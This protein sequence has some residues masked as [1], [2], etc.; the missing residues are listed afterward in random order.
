VNKFKNIV[1]L[2]TDGLML[3]NTNSEKTIEYILENED[4]T[5]GTVITNL[6][7]NKY[8]AK[9]NAVAGAKLAF[10]GFKK[11]HPHDTQSIIR[12][13]FDERESD[14]S[15]DASPGYAPSSESSIPEGENAFRSIGLNYI[16]K[17]CND[18]I[19]IFESIGQLFM[20]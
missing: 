6:M 10:C 8:I 3:S 7:F 2:I 1:Q 9:K 15:S 11:L 18:A 14:S 20:K 16:K 17:C 19:E 12:I 4:Y 13:I 5:V